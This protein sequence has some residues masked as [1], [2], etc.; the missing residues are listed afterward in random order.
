MTTD[1]QGDGGET[2]QRTVTRKDWSGHQTRKCGRNATHAQHD[3]LPL[4]EKHYRQWIGKL[5]EK[6]GVER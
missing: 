5:A 4:C 1:S 3:G 6:Y 2:C